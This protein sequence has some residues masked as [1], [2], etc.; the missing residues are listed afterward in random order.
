MHYDCWIPAALSNF[1]TLVLNEGHSL[2]ITL[3]YN[4]QEEQEKPSKKHIQII[5]VNPTEGIDHDKHH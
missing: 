5:E 1:L 3:H 4:M 2:I